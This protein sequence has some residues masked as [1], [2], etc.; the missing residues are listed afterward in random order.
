MMKHELREM[1]KI[2]INNVIQETVNIYHSEASNQHIQLRFNSHEHPVFVTGDKIQLQQIVLNFLVNAANAMK[3]ILP[4]K[5][6]IEINQVLHNN[7]VTVSVR[8]FGSG[9]DETFKDNLFDPFVTSHES[10]L[11][12]G[13]AVCRSI[14]ERHNGKIWAENID[15]G[16]AE[17]FFRLKLI[18]DE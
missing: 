4:E 14:V 9:V 5:K 3:N 10:G 8:D 7:M 18:K 6:I 13:L 16:G 1:G 15:S 11:G 2:D 12:I 17:F